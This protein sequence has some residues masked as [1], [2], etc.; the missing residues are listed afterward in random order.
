MIKKGFIIILFIVSLTFLTACKEDTP[1]DIPHILPNLTGLN[2][3]Q[4]IE[5][6]NQ[7]DINYTFVDIIHNEIRVGRFVSYQEGYSAGMQIEK[8]SDLTLYFVKSAN[9]LPDLTGLNQQEISELMDLYE[10]NYSFV[11]VETQN[12]EIGT[13]VS[14]S[15]N[16]FA[17]E[18]LPLGADITIRI[19]KAKDMRITLPNLQFLNEQE[20]INTLS[21]LSIKYTIE[22]I[23]NNLIPQGEFVSYHE[24]L[25]AGDLIQPEQDIIVYIAKFINR[26]PNLSHKNQTQILQE[27]SRLHVISEI[28]TIA[29]NDVPEG[30]FVMYLNREVGQIVPK[31]ATIIVYVATPIIEVNRN[32][33]FSTYVEGTLY[34]KALE[35]Y[36]VSDEIIDLSEFRI[37]QYLDGSQEINI[38]FNL[39]G[40]LLPKSVYVITHV[41][42]I[43]A[44][45]QK[46]DMQTD[47]LLF[48]GNDSIAL[49]YS[50]GEVIDKI[51]WTVQYLDNRTLS[52]K[53]TILSPSPQFSYSDWDIYSND[54]HQPLGSHP[55]TFPQSFTY[56]SSYLSIPFPENG[57]MI[58]VT[59]I[60]NNDGD[61]AQFN[62]GFTLNDRVRFVGIDTAETGSGTLAT[63]A[64]QFVYQRLSTASEIYLQQD[65]SSGV[66]ETFGRYLAL[67][68]ADGVLLNYELIKNGYAA[69]AYYDSARTFSL[70]GVDLNTWMFLA[71]QYAKTNR[72]GMWG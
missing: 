2:K 13:F 15:N 49:I 1:Q 31:G 12:F 20:I 24:E 22:E 46:A 58:K 10:F 6:L 44:I 19:A 30:Q 45:R 23:E 60:S 27:L 66:R 52:R 48:N 41:E 63:L 37:A 4:A 47:Q 67:V 62:P 68:W 9:T 71:E 35:L 26:L 16:H 11:E 43:Q 70:N 69:N 59:F 51:E 3:T 8:G 39:D 21:L 50:N 56:D 57:G 65:P 53:S 14:F 38:E 34:N 72:L 40:Y 17:G 29:T 32:L 36:N 55:T 61:T 5:R 64:R 18:T 54:N 28:R 33:M 42:A 25:K 7:L